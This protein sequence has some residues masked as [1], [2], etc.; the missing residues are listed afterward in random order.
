MAKPPASDRPAPKSTPKATQTSS[1]LSPK[2][3]TP[4]PKTTQTKV[5]KTDP[6]AARYAALEKAY[7]ASTKNITSTA[8]A[9]AQIADQKAAAKAAKPK[10]TTKPKPVVKKTTPGT[11]TTKKPDVTTS[12]PP[13]V[14]ATPNIFNDSPV[15][16]TVEDAV[17]AAPI[18]T[19]VFVDEAFSNELMTDL[20]F[21]DIGGQELLTLARNDTV[22]GQAVT[23]Q[24]IKNLNI[25]QEIY[26]PSNLL[27]L[28]ETSDKYFANFIIDL[29]SKIPKIGNGED[30]V[31][32]YLD[33]A[34]GSGVIEFVNLKSDEQVE[35]QIASA[36]IIEDVGI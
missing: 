29:R 20:L 5:I 12:A 31:N 26:N 35:L 16:A 11:T 1:S 10:V 23:Y 4:L 13:E 28:Q 32:Y 27:K 25:L 36:G 34:T 3:H 2:G 30:G 7:K 9:A 8:R 24:P 6:S 15:V 17:K 33:F 21:E 14:Y 18:D 19:V 22:N